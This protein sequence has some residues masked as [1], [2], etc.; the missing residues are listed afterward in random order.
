M[1]YQDQLLDV[2]WQQRLLAILQRDFW[3][4][5]RCGGVEDGLH[6]HHKRYRR[7]AAPWDYADDELTTLC[8]DCHSLMHGVVRLG[9]CA[10][11]KAAMVVPTE[12]DY[13]IA[14]ERRAEIRRVLEAMQ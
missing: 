5:T 12:E 13:R 10:A 14:N 7:G 1:S 3:H 6:V 9:K 4:C 2:R 11:F 8:A